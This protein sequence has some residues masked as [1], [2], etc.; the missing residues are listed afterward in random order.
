MPVLRVRRRGN[1]LSKKESEQLQKAREQ[2]EFLD[3]GLCEAMAEDVDGVGMSP[4][5]QKAGGEPH[6]V[7]AK[8]LI[9]EAASQL[10]AQ[11]PGSKR[12]APMS[13]LERPLFASPMPSPKRR[14]VSKKSATKTEQRP[15]ESLAADA[16]FI[17]GRKSSTALVIQGLIDNDKPT[18][19]AKG[20]DV[21]PSADYSSTSQAA[22]RLIESP[23]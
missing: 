12:K 2:A 19:S 15:A 5:E 3:S 18:A 9:K 23:S 16:E 13:K 14:R 21:E 1:I 17:E 20:G 7:S 11:T 22:A 10:P 4:A 8:E 6:I